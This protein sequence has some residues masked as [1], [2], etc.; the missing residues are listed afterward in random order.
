MPYCKSGECLDDYELVEK[1]LKALEI[2]RKYPFLVRIIIVR[3]DTYY[4]L[5]INMPNTNLPTEEEYNL[6]KEVLTNEE[7]S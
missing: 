2:I 3:N 6:L 5:Q 7:K 1:E 4:Q